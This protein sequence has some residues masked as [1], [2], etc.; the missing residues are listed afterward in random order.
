MPYDVPFPIKRYVPQEK[1]KEV[2]GTYLYLLTSKD[3]FHKKKGHLR[4]NKIHHFISQTHYGITE[5][6][7]VKAIKNCSTCQV[8]KTF[9][10]Y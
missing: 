10:Y 8:N 6:D 2:I 4:R 5:D 1:R 7:M 3:W 9:I